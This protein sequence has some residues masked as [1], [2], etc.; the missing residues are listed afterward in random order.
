M[1]FRRY[2]HLERLGQGAHVKVPDWV[3]VIRHKECI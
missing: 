1:T 3:D 2:D